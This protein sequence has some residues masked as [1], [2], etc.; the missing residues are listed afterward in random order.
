M[1][2]PGSIE[3][4]EAESKGR[5]FLH[6][7]GGALAEMTFSKAGAGMIIIDHTEVPEVFRGQGVGV[8]LVERAVEDARATGKKI[9]ALCPFANA[10]FRKHPE[11]AD[12]LNR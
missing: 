3:L 7:P 8:R 4:A 9:A 5:Y 1:S 10:Q 11:W 12:V 6:G 2:E